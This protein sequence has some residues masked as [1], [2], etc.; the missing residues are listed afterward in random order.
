MHSPVSDK[1]QLEYIIV[2][3]HLVNDE[4]RTVF[5]KFWT[6]WKPIR[7]GFHRTI[8]SGTLESDPNLIKH[9][10]TKRQIILH[11]QFLQIET[12]D[13]YILFTI[14]SPLYNFMPILKPE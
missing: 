5:D 1:S 14:F 10:N 13:T 8:Q 4:I 6:K 7:T 2:W 12:K 9:R 11:F 3:K